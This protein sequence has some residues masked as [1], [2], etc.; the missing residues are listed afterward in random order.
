[1]VDAIVEAVLSYLTPIT[2]IAA[3]IVPS[4]WIS[5]AVAV[6]VAMI[7][8]IGFSHGQPNSKIVAAWLIGQVATGIATHFIA[9]K[10]R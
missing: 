1:M 3:L 9:R 10:A 4:V 8:V 2:M 7:G 5:A 6:T